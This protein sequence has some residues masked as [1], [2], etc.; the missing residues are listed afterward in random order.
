M[1]APAG[2]YRGF[3]TTVAMLAQFEDSI[4]RMTRAGW[5]CCR[6]FAYPGRAI[7]TT[8]ANDRI[9]LLSVSTSGTTKSDVPPANFQS[10]VM[11]PEMHIAFAVSGTVRIQMPKGQI[12]AAEEG[13]CL[14]A[15]LRKKSGEDGGFND[16]SLR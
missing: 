9:F 16:I 12:A 14:L 8:C 2:F 5:C 15:S 13:R 10:V 6:A 7:T 11:N 1:C 4:L 3:G